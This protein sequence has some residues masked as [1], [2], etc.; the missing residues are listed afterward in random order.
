[1]G[2]HA[3]NAP[4]SVRSKPNTWCDMTIKWETGDMLKIKGKTYE[5]WEQGESTT[6]LRSLDARHYF[7]TLHN[8]SPYLHPSINYA[9]TKESKCQMTT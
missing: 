7:V 8:T 1:M 9:Q 2:L 4:T 5:V 6:I 3:S